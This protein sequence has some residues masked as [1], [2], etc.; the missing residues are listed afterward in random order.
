MIESDGNFIDR[1]GWLARR[2]LANTGITWALLQLPTGVIQAPGH[3][4]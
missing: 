4:S 2:Q 1:R 3:N